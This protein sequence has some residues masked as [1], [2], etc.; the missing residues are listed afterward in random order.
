MNTGTDTDGES[1]L[2]VRSGT[3]SLVIGG[4]LDVLSLRVEEG[5]SLSVRGTLGVVTGLLVE[6]TARMTVRRCRL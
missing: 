4:Q 2:F 3:V 6:P 1:N 5:A